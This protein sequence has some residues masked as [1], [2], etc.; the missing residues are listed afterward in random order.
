MIELIKDKRSEY[1]VICGEDVCERFAAKELQDFIARCTG[2]VLPIKKE[3]DSPFIAVGSIADKFG[4]S[5]EWKKNTKDGIRRVEKD[6]NIYLFGKRPRSSLYAVYDFLESVFG[7][8]FLAADETFVPETD[9]VSIADM[10]VTEEPSFDIRSFYTPQ[11]EKDSLLT[12]R[13]RQVALASDEVPEYGY[14]LFKDGIITPHNVFEYV[15]FDKYRETHPEFF[16]SVTYEDGRTGWDLCFSQGIDEN[17]EI[18]F[19]GSADI[20]SDNL[21]AKI[22]ENPN[23]TWFSVCQ[24]DVPTGC[25]CEK[26]KKNAA[27]YG[28][29]SGILLRYINAI[30]RK[31]ERWRKE[32]CPDREI[33]LVTFAYAYTAQPP[34]DAN[35]VIAVKPEKNVW[36]WLA[37]ADQ[38]MLY[39]CDEKGQNPE[40]TRLIESWG[41]VCDRFCY[42]DYRINFA[43]YLFYFPGLRVFER[44]FKYLENKG[45]D[46]LF[47]EAASGDKNDSDIW[48]ND[49]K[50]YV[51]SKL[52]W[53]SSLSAEK[54]TREY[55]ELYYGEY[56]D[57]VLRVIELFEDNFE[58]LKKEN[59]Q[60]R[61]YLLLGYRTVESDYYPIEM[62]EEAISSL[63]KALADCSD[64]KYKKRLCNVLCTPQRM[65][66]RNYTSYYPDDEQGKKSLY[67][68]FLIN[69]ER[70]NI[71]VLGGYEFT[72]ENLKKYPDYNWFKMNNIP[73]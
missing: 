52:M 68:E 11:M 29:Y 5:A 10:D 63:K 48:S 35:G 23:V 30:A 7:V 37:T 47:C 15:S 72:L 18:E 71:K 43:E 70:A 21:I 69:C 34:Y 54:L 32:N 33:R 1:S 66:L 51:A 17:G 73:Y 28:G 42:W 20:L 2:V 60:A 49:L 12:A 56:A 67:E 45:I 3:S 4:V 31:V 61:I 46:Y 64:E 14:G 62:L 27:I 44:D 53:N 40:Y 39:A 24:N 59:P 13:L 6:G 57:A 36:I 8:R 25:Q 58:R 16:H 22:A 55:C 26:C 9:T 38:N 50:G 65:L 41:N 19:G